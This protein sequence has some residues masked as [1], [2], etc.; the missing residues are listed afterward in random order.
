MGTGCCKKKMRLK[1]RILILIPKPGVS[2]SLWPNE[3]TMK[4]PRQIVARHLKLGYAEGL[5][6]LVRITFLFK[7]S[8]YSYNNT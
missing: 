4:P 1:V 5:R 8:A 2:A 3:K 7:I 6:T